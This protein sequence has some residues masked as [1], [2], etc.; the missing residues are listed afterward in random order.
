MRTSHN[1]LY[2]ALQEEYF[3]ERDAAV[4]TKMYEVAKKVSRNY[5]N[6]YCRKKGIHL[7]NLDEMSHDSAIFVIDQ[8]LRKPDFKIT[9]I[10]A[11]VHFGVIKT[12]FCNK[13]N[14]RKE[15]SYET[16]VEGGWDKRL[17]ILDKVMD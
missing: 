13:D 1:A 3:R 8:Y 5:L 16:I 17:S 15:V 10:S 2:D 14:E 11:Y 7:G 6:N 9:K 12:L 4:L